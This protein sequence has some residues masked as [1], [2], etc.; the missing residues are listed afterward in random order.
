VLPNPGE[1]CADERVLEH[2]AGAVVKAEQI[3]FKYES[4]SLPALD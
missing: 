3:A 4:E 2:S 1:G